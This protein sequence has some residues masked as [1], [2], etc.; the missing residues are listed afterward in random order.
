MTEARDNPKIQIRTP[1]PEDY[2]RLAELAGQLG[3]PSTSDDIAR[4][5][6]DLDASSAYAVFLAEQPTQP[7]EIAGWVCIVIHRTLESEPFA[8][9]TGFIVDE[10][11]RSKKV[12]EKLLARAEQW[13]RE[14][15]INA[16]RLRSNVMRDRAHAFYLRHGYEHH[17]TQK[18]FRKILE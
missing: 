17:K 6:A 18:A 12:G 16:V 11:H 4:R 15:G 13:A 8:E 5:I 14:Q 7:T 1:R 2:S 9:I 3:Y 10:R